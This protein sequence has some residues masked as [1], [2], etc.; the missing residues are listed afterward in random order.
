MIG[1]MIEHTFTVFISLS[2]FKFAYHVC[3]KGHLNND[4][5]LSE[6]AKSIFPVRFKY[7]CKKQVTSELDN[8][9]FF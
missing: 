8:D 5:I 4:N 6:S 3:Q 7:Y 9:T 2:A 1:Y